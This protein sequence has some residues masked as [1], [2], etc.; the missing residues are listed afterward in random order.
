M[1]RYPE[2]DPVFLSIGPIQFRWYGLMYL[3]AFL[4]SYWV[5]RWISRSRE[6]YLSRD[7]V[8][9]LVFFVAVGIV[10][11]GRLGYVIFYNLPVYLATPLKILAVWEG[12]MSF[13]GGL[14]GGIAGG[15][16][17]AR[18][19]GIEPLL[20]ADTAFLPAPIGLMFGRIGNFINGE[21]Y[22]RVTDLPWGMV[23]PAG[24]A[25]PRHPSQ[26]YEAILEG[27]FL[28]LSLLLLH[29]SPRCRKGILWA[30]LGLYGVIRFSV[31]FAREPDP[32]IGYLVGGL[33][34]G[35]ILSIPM[36]A[37]GF[38]LFMVQ[39]VRNAGTVR[40]VSSS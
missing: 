1:I 25:L 15:Y 16:L 28:F 20:L 5:V 31:E 18:K 29:R 24:G 39:I 21:L 17:F 12:G 14:L 35:Q 30:F 19:R 9:D 8:A 34:M 40:G 22:G 3:L 38:S 4:S 6:P 26:L 2:I 11:G 36:I 27:P 37:V 13:H 23:F 33:S 32:H 7:D 10:L